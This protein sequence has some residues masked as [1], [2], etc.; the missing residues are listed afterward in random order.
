MKVKFISSAIL[1][2]T[3]LCFSAFSAFAQESEPVVIDEVVAQV[4]DSVITLSRVKRE[5]QA[6]ADALVQQG[7]KP[8]EA[9]A[10]VEKKKG[11]LIASLINEEL[12]LQ[13]GKDLGMDADVD[14]QI[15]QRF[16]QLMTQYKLKRVEDLY[17]AMND[18]GVKPD[19]LR[20]LWRKDITKQMVLQHEVSSKYYYSRGEKEIKDYYDTHKDKFT[21]P[22]TV[23]L[24]EIFL[25]FAG[26]DTAA[27]RAKA[28]QLIAQA[29]SGA[30]FTKL[31]TEN[32]DRPDAA[33]TKGSVGTLSIK[34][35]NPQVAD[36][37]KGLKTGDVAKLEVDEGVEIIRVDNRTAASNDS[38]FDEAAVRSAMTAEAFPEEQKKYVA[39]LRKDAYIKVSDT[40]SP[41]V[42]P[43]LTDTT[44]AAET[45]KASK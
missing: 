29:R 10:E 40:Y 32:S 41:L 38:V 22:E 5:M 43:L 14:V 11:E 13:K 23:S 6:A 1:F 21:K 24:S 8:D 35:L 34:E 16:A 9:K 30:D 33:Q 28:D 4:N 31:V 39:G 44:A 42:A 2:V 37:I 36:A 18:Q 45:K 27:I 12:I 19:E 26:R 3:V 15:N 20:E 7:K 17:K 25:G